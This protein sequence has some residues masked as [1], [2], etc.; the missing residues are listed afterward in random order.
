MNS[1]CL[2]FIHWGVIFTLFWDKVY[3][4]HCFILFLAC[5][6]WLTGILLRM[7]VVQSILISHSGNRVDERSRKWVEEQGELGTLSDHI[8]LPCYYLWGEESCPVS[9]KWGLADIFSDSG[10]FFLN[11]CP[12]GFWCGSSSVMSM[13]F[14]GTVG[15][16]TN[17]RLTLSILTGH[18]QHPELSMLCVRETPHLRYKLL[19]HTLIK[20]HVFPPLSLSTRG[21]NL[22]S[23]D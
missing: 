7:Y 21:K 3:I 11:Y 14:Q 4:C 23:E 22:C 12:K 17:F 18:R 1:C 5:W 8:K 20:E 9:S 15:I 19:V 10:F 2:I 6:I 13:T 16:W